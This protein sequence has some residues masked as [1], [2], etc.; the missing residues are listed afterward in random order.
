[1]ETKRRQVDEVRGVCG[2]QLV[3][4]SALRGKTFVPLKPKRGD[5]VGSQRIGVG[6]RAPFDLLARPVGWNIWVPKHQHKSLRSRFAASGQGSGAR[7][8]GGSRCEPMPNT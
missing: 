4:N 5:A 6:W 1:M 8:L 2:A 3:G 7:T